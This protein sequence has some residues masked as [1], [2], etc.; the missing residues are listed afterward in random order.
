MIFLVRK[1]VKLAELR[2]KKKEINEQLAT[3]SYLILD[4]DIFAGIIIDLSR[5]MSRIWK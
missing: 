1:H 2:T 5:S 3:F 4:M